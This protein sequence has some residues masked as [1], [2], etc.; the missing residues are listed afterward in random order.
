MESMESVYGTDRTRSLSNDDEGVHITPEAIHVS[1]DEYTDLSSL[2]ERQRLERLFLTMAATRSGSILSGVDSI[3]HVSDEIT[4]TFYVSGDTSACNRRMG[5][6]HCS[7]RRAGMK[8][9]GGGSAGR[10]I[11]DPFKAATKYGWP[12]EAQELT[13]DRVA[14]NRGRSVFSKQDSPSAMKELYRDYYEWCDNSDDVS[15][16]G[17]V[18]T[19]DEFEAKLL[20]E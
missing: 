4:V 13:A 10:G 7:A 2:E 18:P 17:E 20:S 6:Q 14:T 11:N 1:S 8:K 16:L 12:D 15:F 19:P 3:L 9:I 5:S